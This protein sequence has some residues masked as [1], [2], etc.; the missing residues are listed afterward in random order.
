MRVTRT[1]SNGYFPFVAD[2]N[3]HYFFDRLGGGFFGVA[4]VA[5]VI[6]EVVVALLGA[7]GIQ[8]VVVLGGDFFAYLK[9]RVA[10]FVVQ[11]GA[12]DGYLAAD[13]GRGDFGGEL[14]SE[15]VVMLGNLAVALLVFDDV[16]RRTIGNPNRNPK[17]Q[18]D[19]DLSDR[20]G[21]AG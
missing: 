20:N 18:S 17:L 13:V 15:L 7:I 6:G 14:V 19:F 1:T 4:V 9:E 16:L 5:A 10:K 8:P 21:R 12:A 2:C 3:L 11:V